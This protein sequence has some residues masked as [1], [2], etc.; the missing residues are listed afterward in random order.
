MIILGLLILMIVRANF[1]THSILYLKRS[2]RRSNLLRIFELAHLLLVRRMRKL[3]SRDIGVW[4]LSQKGLFQK[5]RRAASY[6]IPVCSVSCCLF[7][8]FWDSF[9]QLLFQNWHRL[10]KKP[11][12]RN[13]DIIN[14]HPQLTQMLSSLL[15]VILSS[16][17]LWKWAGQTK[18]SLLHQMWLISGQLHLKECSKVS[19]LLLR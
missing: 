10:T 13:L 1:R 6:L 2:S 16:R 18:S 9:S 19:F 11:L 4:A 14:K 17:C 15:T 8:M 5:I 3:R 12:L 7:W